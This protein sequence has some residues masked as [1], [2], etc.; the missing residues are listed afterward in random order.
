MELAD[1]D[2]VKD[3]PGTKGGNG[4]NVAPVEQEASST[5]LLLLILQEV[6][7]PCKTFCWWRWWRSGPYLHPAAGRSGGGTGG[8]GGAAGKKYRHLV[9]VQ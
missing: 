7:H 1:T 8:A 3:N 6:G 4:F 2:Q 9:E 5:F